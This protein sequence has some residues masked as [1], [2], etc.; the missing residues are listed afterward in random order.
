VYP[1]TGLKPMVDVI[2][3]MGLKTC[4]YIAVDWFCATISLVR[5]LSNHFRRPILN[6]NS[7]FGT[8]PESTLLVTK[9]YTPTKFDL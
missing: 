2:S 7:F 3:F 8:A 4:F 1:D 5:D 9:E 6:L